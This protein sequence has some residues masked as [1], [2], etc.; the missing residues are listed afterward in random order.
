[1]VTYGKGG[2]E[3]E[4]VSYN[5]THKIAA[6]E[7]TSDRFHIF[8][9]ILLDMKTMDYERSI[10]VKFWETYFKIEPI[11]FWGLPVI[12]ALNTR[13][14]VITNQS[15]L[16]KAVDKS[17]SHFSQTPMT[18]S[19]PHASITAIARTRQER[20]LSWYEVERSLWT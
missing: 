4:V 20:P 5:Y 3:K 16:V 18:S 9:N 12:R 15:L 11:G 8:G 7:S 2:R 17:L 6:G 10:L 19:Q 1:M 14:I 13:K